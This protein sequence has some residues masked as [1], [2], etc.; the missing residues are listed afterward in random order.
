MY[1][2]LAVITHIFI[3][4]GPGQKIWKPLFAMNKNA[5]VMFL[6]LP[7]S[8]CRTKYD[9]HTDRQQKS[10]CEGPNV[11]MSYNSIVLVG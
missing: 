5:S 1:K 8:R 4:L 2:H 11:E 3:L 6:I 10:V 7:K 9:L